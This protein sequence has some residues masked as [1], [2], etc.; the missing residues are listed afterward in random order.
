MRRLIIEPVGG[1]ANRLRALFSAEI[2]AERLDARLD[3]AWDHEDP[4][5]ACRVEALF[6]GLSG[7]PLSVCR[8]P[9]VHSLGS[10]SSGRY[11][12]PPGER[13]PAVHIRTSETF[14]LASMPLAEF[15]EQWRARLRDLKP[16]P[17]VAERVLSIPHDAIG[18]HIRRTDHW[19][20]TR[21][22]PLR[23][24]IDQ[25][26]R[27]LAEEPAA[28][29]YLASDSA[30]VHALVR[31]RFGD[32]VVC[33]PKRDYHR[34]TQEGIED[35]LVDLLCLARTRRIYGCYMS[36]FSDMAA[37]L[38]GTEYVTLHVRGAPRAWDDHAVDR[39][40]HTR[41]NWDE[42]CGRWRSAESGGLRFRPDHL[43]LQAATAYVTS[44]VYQ[45]RRRVLKRE[46]ERDSRRVYGGH[47]IVFDDTG[48]EAPAP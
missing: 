31:E 17:H 46:Y 8:E 3:I 29:F 22:S 10:V 2:L 39:W 41:M 15:T 19:R 5:C 14:R 13:V 9:G 21:Y 36:S 6:E 16:R 1:L 4:I 26:E 28:C 45:M 48:D 30:Q 32:R 40:H 24:F 34:T 12:W 37:D 23:L 42:A 43:F 44:P 27:H 47:G 35:G 33:Y 38:G 25:I 11:N 7:V 20:A 18:L